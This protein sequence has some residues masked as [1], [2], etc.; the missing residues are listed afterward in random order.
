MLMNP[1]EVLNPN[2]SESIRII[3][4]SDSSGLKNWSGFIRIQSLELT[5]IKW[6]R[7]S[8]DL[9]QTTLKTLGLSVNTMNNN[10]KFFLLIWIYIRMVQKNIFS[11]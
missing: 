10:K 4:T 3:P 1:C 7:F 9:H 6:D 11:I 5:R 2:E 8:T